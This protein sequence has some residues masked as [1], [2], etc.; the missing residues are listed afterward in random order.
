MTEPTTMRC[1]A[2]GGEYGGEAG[3]RLCGAC[4]VARGKPDIWPAKMIIGGPFFADGSIS[5]YKAACPCCGYALEWAVET[6]PI[7]LTLFSWFDPNGEGQRITE[8]PSCETVLPEGDLTM[9]VVA[10]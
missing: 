5:T 4:W 9:A 3:P 7:P 8:C 6:P 1:V 2:C 10:A